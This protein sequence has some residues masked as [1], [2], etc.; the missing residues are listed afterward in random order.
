MTHFA[1]CLIR[2]NTFSVHEIFIVLILDEETN[3]T[4]LTCAAGGKLKWDSK[5]LR[6]LPSN[7][8]LYWNQGPFSFLYYFFL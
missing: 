6:E 7:L 5:E 2:F 4:V 1:E 3:G 8:S